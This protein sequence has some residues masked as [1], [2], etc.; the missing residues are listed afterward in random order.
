V[1][2]TSFRITAT[3]SGEEIKGAPKTLSISET[4]E[5]QTN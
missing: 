3:Y 1:S 2:D 5:I 4:M